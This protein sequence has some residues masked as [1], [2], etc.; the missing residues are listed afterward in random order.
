MV[1]F[2]YDDTGSDI[3]VRI[4]NANGIAIDRIYDVPESQWNECRLTTLTFT[5]FL[6]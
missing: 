4:R 5:G 1:D 3:Y 6:S 2:K